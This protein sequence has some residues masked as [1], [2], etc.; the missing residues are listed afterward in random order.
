MEFEEFKQEITEG[1]QKIYGGKADIAVREIVKNNGVKYNGILI[2]LKDSGYRAVPTISLDDFYDAFERGR[3]NMGEC[4]RNIYHAR[5]A[6]GNEKET[7]Q[8][9][10]E[11]FDWEMVKDNV[12]PVLLSTEENQ[13][14][15][16]KLVS[17]PVLDL[18]IVYIIRG[19]LSGGNTGSVKVSRGLLESYGISSEQLHEQA[20]E[21]LEKD[22]YRFRNMNT[23]LKDMGCQEIIEEAQGTFYGRMRMPEMYVLTNSAGMYGAAGILN[24]KLM[25]EFAG[26]RD[27]IILPS[28][29][30]ETI[31]IPAT[32]RID[33]GFCDEMVSEVNR[34]AVAAEERLADHSYYYDAEANE[35]RMCA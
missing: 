1:L 7:E 31:F 13:E 11:I 15:I 2:A 22:G 17:I 9:V 18:S 29:T 33:K 28:S 21:N 16:E 10:G 3:M 12:Y 26:G 4:I 30:H 27:F 32:D 25:R 35:I 14:I 20:M 19:E 5:E 34:T 23:M 6:Y 24:K 8:F